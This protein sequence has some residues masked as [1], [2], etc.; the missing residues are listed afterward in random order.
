MRLYLAPTSDERNQL[1]TSPET[2]FATRQALTA[3]FGQTSPQDAALLLSAGQ[4]EAPQA[5]GLTPAATRK[6]LCRLRAP[7]RILNPYALPNPGP[8]LTRFF[9]SAPLPPLC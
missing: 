5:P 1:L 2:T 6:R 3:I 4:G 8:G 7:S 9:G